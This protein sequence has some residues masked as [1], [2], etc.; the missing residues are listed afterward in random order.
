MYLLIPAVELPCEG[1]GLDWP[2]PGEAWGCHVR[3]NSG[4]RQALGAEV[5]YKKCHLLGRQ[6][7]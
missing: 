3:L 5:G 2:A 4:D 1:N 6:R 7:G